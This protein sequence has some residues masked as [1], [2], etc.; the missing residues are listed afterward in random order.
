[1]SPGLARG[2]FGHEQ[3]K[4]TFSDWLGTNITNLPLT[5]SLAWSGGVVCG[6]RA[7]RKR[8]GSAFGRPAGF[9]VVGVRGL[10]GWRAGRTFAPA[11]C[12]SV[13]G[14]GEE[15]SRWGESVVEGLCPE[16]WRETLT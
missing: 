6:V 16:C 12:W 8:R 2:F 5:G 15:L 13:A 9:S 7:A 1:M 11:R 14:V 3:S 10:F 4:R